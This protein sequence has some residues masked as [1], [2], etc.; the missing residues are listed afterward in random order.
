MANTD[1]IDTTLLGLPAGERARL[2]R[3]LLLSLDEQVDDNVDEAWKVE[4]ERRY[5]DYR[6][7]NVQA[8]DGPEAI[9]EARQTIR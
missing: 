5:A 9:R 4:A 7:G 6:A 3:L 2:A 1:E 8:V